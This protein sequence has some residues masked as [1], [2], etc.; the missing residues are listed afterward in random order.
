MQLLLQRAR[1]GAGP[2]LLRGCALALAQ[3]QQALL[4]GQLPAPGAGAVEAAGDLRR[5]A[6]AAAR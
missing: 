2:L 3:P 4:F 1:R 6:A 5:G